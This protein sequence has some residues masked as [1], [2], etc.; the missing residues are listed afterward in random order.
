ML[1][2]HFAWCYWKP[3]F[4]FLWSWGCT[5]LLYRHSFD[6]LFDFFAVTDAGDKVV[7]N[8]HSKAEWC[9]KCFHYAKDRLIFITIP[10]YLQVDWHTIWSLCTFVK[11]MAPIVVIVIVEIFFWRLN[12]CYWKCAT[13]ESKDCPNRTVFLQ[14]LETLR[15]IQLNGTLRINWWN[16]SGQ[17]LSFPFLTNLITKHLLLLQ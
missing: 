17:T 6:Y 4:H 16:Y 8:L 5:S 10:N 13:W 3:F 14:S 7:W 12:S 11:C 2:T 15:L 1:P 9:L